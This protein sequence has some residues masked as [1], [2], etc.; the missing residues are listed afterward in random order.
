MKNIA[1][2]LAGGA[3]HRMHSDIPKQYMDVNGRPVLFYSLKQ[4]QECRF[5][6]GIILVTRPEDI[7]YCRSTFVEKYSFDKIT[8]I[9]AG[10]D[11]RYKSVMNGLAQIEDADYIFVHDG[12]RPCITQNILT[13][14]YD[15]VKKHRST[16]AAVLSKDTVRISD[17]MGFG[18]STPARNRVWI[19]QTPQVFEA[20]LLIEAY[21]RMKQS[22]SELAVTDDAM[23]VE[24]FSGVKTHMCETTYTNIK[25]TTPEDIFTIEEFLKKI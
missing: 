25:I 8:S 16:V 6:D 14:L 5:I 2:V 7:E 17:E 4:F 23:V 22:D 9:V 18:D 11:E 3:G 10:G 1:I 13:S 21:N 19:I 20:K 12:A 15:D 24:T